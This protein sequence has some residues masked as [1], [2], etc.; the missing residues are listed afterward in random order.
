MHA[1]L[2]DPAI[3]CS[4]M[5]E[6]LLTFSSH[7][8]RGAAW[9]LRGC[10]LAICLGILTE[11]WLWSVE[12]YFDSL[13]HFLLAPPSREKFTHGMESTWALQN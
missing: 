5:Q 6:P 4:L 11:D 9:L 3:E 10:Q 7:P 8:L 1:K 13:S 2:A 12:C